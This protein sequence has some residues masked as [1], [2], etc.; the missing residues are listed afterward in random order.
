VIDV[1]K[2][3][4]TAEVLRERVV[5]YLVLYSKFVDPL[6]S[7]REGAEDEMKAELEV[8]LESVFPRKRFL[9]WMDLPREEKEVQLQEL[10]EVVMGVRV[11][12]KLDLS[13]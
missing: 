9:Y 10:A 2:Y 3:Y 4:E 6:S 5:Y 7:V 13:L 12:N 1:R 11:F 8:A